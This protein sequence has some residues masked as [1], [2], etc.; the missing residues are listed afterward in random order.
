MLHFRVVLGNVARV[1]GSCLDTHWAVEEDWDLRQISVDHQFVKQV[2]DFLGPVDG[3]CR[4]DDDPPAFDTCA[5]FLAENIP[6]FFIAVESIA[7][8]RLHKE[9]IRAR[10]GLRFVQNRDAVASYVTGK[11]NCLLLSARDFRLQL[12]RGSAEDMALSVIAETD[13][14]VKIVPVI[15]GGRLEEL[16]RGPRVCHPKKRQC[17][18]VF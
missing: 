13:A 3:E 4:N 11:E 6:G 15:E 5:D 16:E 10:V 1:K 18:F 2:E 12:D 17:R 8:G 7:V 14:R 9:D